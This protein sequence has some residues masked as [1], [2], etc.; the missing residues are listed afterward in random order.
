MSDREPGVSSFGTAPSGAT[1][2]RIVLRDGRI[3]VSLLTWGAILQGLWLRGHDRSLT[4]G[5]ETMEPYLGDMCYHGALVGPVANRF[6]DATAPVAGVPHRFEANQA[7]RHMLHSGSTGT[8][9]KVWQLAEVTET[10]VTLSV[11]LPHGEG[12]FPGNRRVTARFSVSDRPLPTLRM[13]V[14]GWTDRPTVMNFANHAY[15]NM[16]GSDSWAGHRLRIAADH[17]LPVTED[18]TPTGEIAPV[19]GTP[20]DLRAG[21]EIRPGHPAMDHN[22]CLSSTRTELRDVL[23]LTGTRGLTMTIATT[24]PGMQV[25]D[26]RRTARPGAP[27]Y[28][29][30]AI[31]PQFWPDAPNNPD[32][33]QIEIGPE[34]RYRQISEWRFAEPGER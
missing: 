11:E 15:W 30:L 10:A 17:Y 31:E 20:M 34:D 12:G 8:F 6:T 16:D 14:T 21:P 23:W 3:T 25:Y 24:E 22:F 7:G 1:V 13:E 26:A 19:A 28:E 27:F 5:A 29:G 18:F 4:L 32:F 33:P 9:A 2:H